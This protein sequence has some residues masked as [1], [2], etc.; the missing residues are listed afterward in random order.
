MNLPKDEVII[1]MKVT[2]QE[3]GTNDE[4]EYTLVGA[5][6][7]DPAAGKISVHAPL[8]QGLLG[9]KVGEEVMIQLPAGKMKFKVLKI[10]PAL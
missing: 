1:G 8:A 3:E 5:E 6:E 10:E 2:I 9:H 7:A 4:Y